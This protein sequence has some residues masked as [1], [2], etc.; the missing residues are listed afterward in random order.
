MEGP[1]G[2]YRTSFLL[3]LRAAGGKGSLV[4]QLYEGVGRGLQ[5]WAWMR[6]CYK[7]RVG[8]VVCEE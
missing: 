7:G 1:A 2:T 4:L 6:M 5:W 3:G 8:V